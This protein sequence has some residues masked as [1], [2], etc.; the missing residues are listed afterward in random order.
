M[1]NARPTL[2]TLDLPWKALCTGYLVVAALGLM[3]S[4]AQIFLTH[5]MAD[6]ELGLS[7]DDVVYSYYGD[8]GNSRLE[9]KLDGTMK[10]KANTHDR[11]AIV[12]WVRAG[13]S[14]EAWDA[15]IAGIVVTNCV[16]CHGTI[17][18]LP[19]FRSYEGVRPYA[20]IDEGASVSDLARVSH[21][22]LFGIAFIYVFVCGIF[23]LSEALPKWLRAALVAT[24]F[25]FLV[26][27]VLSWWLTKWWPGFAWL[28]IV[29]GTV[30]NL[31]AALM[32]TRSLWE[33]WFVRPPH[34]AGAP[35]AP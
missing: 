4:G 31:A 24:P 2:R 34:P 6:G 26:L 11:A 29:G 14:R 23:A 25:A 32:I 1:P 28:T 33:L 9:A 21:I 18:G 19:D 7:V 16:K 27:D 30:N 12:R 35:P 15:Q 8:R 17:P 13:S 10:D 20:A 22:H 5:G 3:M